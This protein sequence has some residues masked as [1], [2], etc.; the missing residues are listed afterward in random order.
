VIL[1][2]VC[3]KAIAY[4]CSVCNSKSDHHFMKAVRLSRSF[5][6]VVA[7]TLATYWYYTVHYDR[8]D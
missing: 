7:Q 1:S 5:A 6:F 3:Y 4:L 8:S 2:V